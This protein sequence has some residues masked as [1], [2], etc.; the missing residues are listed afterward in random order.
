[1]LGGCSN[2]I[3]TSRE[4]SNEP[5]TPNSSFTGTIKEINRNKALVYAKLGG[6]EGKVFVDLSMNDDEVFQI[7]D[8]V[9]VG[10]DGTIRESNPAQIKYIFY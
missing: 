10:Y 3:D 1:M 5:K 4:E 9:K 2:S 8:G 7:G 6:G